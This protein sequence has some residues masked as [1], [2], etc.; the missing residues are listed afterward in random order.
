MNLT[1]G[2]IIYR[3]FMWLGGGV[4][5]TFSPEIG[6]GIETIFHIVIVGIALIAAIAKKSPWDRLLK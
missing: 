2:Y 6:I 3:I 5:A 4:I 1:I